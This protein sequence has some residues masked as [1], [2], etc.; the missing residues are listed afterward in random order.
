M[1]LF[2]VV[3]D[4]P[5]L[6][7]AAYTA[8]DCVGGVLAFAGAASAYAN[9]GVIKRLTIIDADKEDAVLRL[10]LFDADPSATADTDAATFL[11][12]AAD[13]AKLIG[14]KAIAAADY[15]DSTSDSV[16][17]F[18]MDMPFVL[19]AGGTTLYGVLVCTGTPTYTAA[20]DLTVKRVISRR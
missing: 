16:A 9:E 5:A 11:P 6:S 7:L 20:D 3:S 12:A 8:E 15:K 10:Y 2:T 18:E 14:F 4:V 1:G 17:V 19:A 13:L